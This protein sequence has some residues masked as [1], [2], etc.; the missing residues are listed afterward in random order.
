[1]FSSPSFLISVAGIFNVFAEHCN[2]QKSSGNLPYQFTL[3]AYNLTLPNAN[4]TG[5][6]LVLGQAGAISGAQLHVTS[7][8]RHLRLHKSPQFLPYLSYRHMLLI[9]TTIGQHLAFMIHPY[10]RTIATVDG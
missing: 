10:M 5:A 4:S 7:V 2:A 3:S 1:M 9:L 6:P 8:R